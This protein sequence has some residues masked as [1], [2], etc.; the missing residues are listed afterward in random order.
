MCDTKPSA[1]VVR[2]GRRVTE[3]GLLSQWTRVIIYGAR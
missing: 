3:K 1:L 2:E